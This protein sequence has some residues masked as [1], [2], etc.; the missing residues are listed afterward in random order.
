MIILFQLLLL[1]I[2]LYIVVLLTYSLVRGAPF[3]AIG[4]RRMENIFKLLNKKGGRFVDIGSGDGRI[5]I[6]AAK[7]G[8][9]AYGI[10][11]NP[12]LVIIANVKIRK[13]KLVN[14]HILLTDF[15]KHDFS[16]YEYVTVWGAPHMMSALERKLMNELKP[17]A[18]VV[19]NHFLFPN[20][21]I[22]K[23]LGD[24]HLYTKGE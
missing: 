24:V 15:W 5:V 23:S 17:G 10:E 4:K 16:R 3:A 20:W 13:L 8:F 19:S 14:A 18:K 2:L 11:I 6:N 1:I 12:L 22:T 7:R 9:D 21:K